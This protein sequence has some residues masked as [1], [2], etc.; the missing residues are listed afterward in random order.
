MS[1]SKRSHFAIVAALLL[2][3]TLPGMAA[4][5]TYE[6]LLNPE[7][8][9][10]LTNNLTYNSN[11]YSTLDEINKDTVKNLKLAFAVPF[12]PPSQ[13][14]SFATSALQGTPLV[15]DGI[16]WATDGWGRVYR[17]DMTKG[18]RG[19]I[20]WIMDPKTDPEIAT[21]ILNNRGVALYGDSVYSMSP[22][23]RLIRTDKATGE[24][25]W[26]VETQQ[27]PAEYFSPNISRWRPS[28]S[29]ARSSSD[30]EAAMARCAAA[31]R[32]VIPRT[33]IYCGRS[34][35]CR[36]KASRATKP[37]RTRPGR[38]VVRPHG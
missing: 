11:R 27:N 13:G 10:W 12:M 38:R 18:D 16:M 14:S 17:V 20:D 33:A 4:D 15:E 31:S 25:K 32:P 6:R 34:G 35:R 8:G 22:D 28:P 37:G 7:P 26:E 3:T 21:G 2:G 19:Y 24:V 9:N 23:G 5:V 36:A 29:T 1:I 30:R